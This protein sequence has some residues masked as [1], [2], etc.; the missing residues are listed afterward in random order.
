MGK[1]SHPLMVL[2]CAL[3]CSHVV[4]AKLGCHFP[5]TFLCIMPRTAMF[6]L[7][8][9]A[10]KLNFKSDRFVLVVRFMVVSVFC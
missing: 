7:S 1:P 6:L 4:K 3:Q 8:V 9:G 10:A 2:I 5:N